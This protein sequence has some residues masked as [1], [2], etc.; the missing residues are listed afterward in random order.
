MPPGKSQKECQEGQQTLKQL[1]CIPLPLIPV[2]SLALP[3][4]LF[5]PSFWLLLLAFLLSGSSLG[6]LEL[7][8]PQGA[9]QGGLKL[10][11]ERKRPIK[12]P[13]RG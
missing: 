8:G 12:G 10:K 6:S 5:W 3:W 1:G 4:A 9:N 7:R 11:K 13:T 2:L